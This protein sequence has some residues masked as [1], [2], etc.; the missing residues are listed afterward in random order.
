MG[1]QGNANYTSG[2]G[3]L[4]PSP[5]PG[6]RLFPLPPIQTKSPRIAAAAILPEVDIRAGN[7]NPVWK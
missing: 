6:N 1:I 7:R 4:S 2:A 3:P 5:V